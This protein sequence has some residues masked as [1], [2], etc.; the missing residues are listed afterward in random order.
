MNEIAIP[1]KLV[2][3]IKAF[4]LDDEAA[5]LLILEAG[6][7]IC[8]TESSSMS[9]HKPTLSEAELE[10]IIALMRAFPQPTP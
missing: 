9:L 5:K 7:A 1:E 6:K 3:L 2:P 4:S 8:K 10:G